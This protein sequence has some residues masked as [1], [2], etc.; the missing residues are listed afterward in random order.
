[1]AKAGRSSSRR[2]NRGEW[3]ELIEQWHRSG[4]SVGVFC[5]DQDLRVSTFSW[6]RWR[7]GSD[8]ALESTPEPPLAVEAGSWLRWSAPASVP[9]GEEAVAFEL[10]WSD[11]LTLRV[12]QGFD[13]SALARLLSV[14]EVSGC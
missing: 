11:G 10:R 7:L 13:A 8:Q 6:W 9:G 2:R 1:M 12:P 5:A 3:Q 4:Q 14:L